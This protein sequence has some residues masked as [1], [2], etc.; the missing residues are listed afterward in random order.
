MIAV[1]SG[2]VEG[3]VVART[4]AALIAL[5]RS[6]RCIISRFAWVSA[7]DVARSRCACT[8]A[9]FEDVVVSAAA[10]SSHTVATSPTSAFAGLDASAAG[11]ALS[12]LIC[13]GLRA[14]V[15]RGLLRMAL[16][17]G[18]GKFGLLMGSS[19][20]RAPDDMRSPV[21]SMVLDDGISLV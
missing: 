3:R 4:A 16:V 6:S 20:W 5:R 7:T 2:L 17:Y 21:G 8:L 13:L 1:G 11:A 19:T 14:T 10:T 15:R 12:C 18:L 9:V